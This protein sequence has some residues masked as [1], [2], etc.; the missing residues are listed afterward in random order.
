[1]NE[2]SL[3]YTDERDKSYGI[4]GMAITLVA[5]D[6]EHLLAEIH[7]DAEPGECMVMTH[8][9]GFK[10]NPRMSAKIVWEQ[11]LK[12]LRITT[13]MALGNL[14]CRR[15][16]LAG[17]GL[18]QEETDG[19]RDAVRT[20]A[21]EHCSLEDDEADRLFDSCYRYVDRIFRHSGIRSVADGFA[22][23]LTRRRTL[24]AVEAIELLAQLGLR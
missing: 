9:F 3:R 10:G 22:D 1:M 20:E 18:S 8:D 21:H 17:K 19:L 4:A 13:S 5:C 15:Y 16:I 23:H 14:A 12:D 7:L 11:T 24:S 2:P 6:G